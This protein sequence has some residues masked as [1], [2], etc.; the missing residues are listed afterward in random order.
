MATPVKSG[1]EFKANTNTTGA[2]QNPSIAGLSG[3]GF[4][5]TWTSDQDS[6]DSYGIYAQR[7]QADGTAVGSEF[8][9]NTFTTGFQYAPAVSGLNDGGFIV[10]W[11][12][13]GQAGSGSGSG[14]GYYDVFGQRYDANGD[15]VGSEFQINS[16]TPFNQYYSSVAALSDGG[17]VVTWTDTAQ[18]QAGFGGY[19]VYGQRYTSAGIATGGEFHI[20]THT[21]D[22]Q[23]FSDV[24]AFSGGG[25]VVV[26]ESQD[27]DTS[28]F[29]WGIYGQR[30][31]SNG[32]A[33]GTEFRIN[34]HVAGD[35][36]FPTVTSLASGFVVT[37][38]SD[39]QDGS[40]MGIY[41]QRFAAN[42][43]ASGSEFQIN[44]YT[45]SL[46]DRPDVT[47]LSDGGFVVTWQSYGQDG[48]GEGV[49]GQRFDADGSTNGSEFLV[50]T[51][52]GSD[53]EDPTI[54]ALSNGDFAVAWVATVNNGGTWSRDIFGQVFSTTGPRFT[55]GDDTVVLNDSGETV[56]ALGGN[57][58]VG[59]G[60]G[61]DNI[62]GGSGSDILA[63]AGGN[64]TLDGGS[65]DVNE[66]D[67]L[68]G[69]AGNDTYIVNSTTSA[70]DIVDEGTAAPT[71]G[72]VDTIISKGDFFWDYY[73][74]GEILTIDPSAP[75]GATVVASKWDCTLNGNDKDNILLPY[76]NDNTINP[77]AGVDVIGL[78]L[79]GLD[80]TFNG[81]N[82][83]NFT[84]GDDTNYIYD[85]ESGTD[86]ID[87]SAYGR[88]ADG[89]QMLANVADTDWGSFV[90]MG[91]HEGADEY[92]G[93]VGL[94]QADLD[95]GDFMV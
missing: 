52:T 36:R 92:I 7:Y 21:D 11:Q 70:I 47:A 68:Y 37:W 8:Q 87:V 39:G 5:V 88:F 9:V 51:N 73:N 14:T 53:E 94:H 28:G 40:S 32:A 83:M 85:F 6:D 44:T 4:V 89:A 23:D 43:T 95:A 72:E 54:T 29:G 66:I 25:F 2:Q 77:G 17:Y 41:G 56:D 22:H 30:Y 67:Y 45:D 3:G 81:T 71:P 26:W 20:N 84:P 79:Y 24:A 27:Q 90:W 76:G 13:E 93:I 35:Q 57:D 74:V 50:P 58:I 12:S 42:G 48:A 86:K 80:S 33:A 49:Y 63:G 91:V 75:S 64:D 55:E 31:D 59:G 18:D 38:E 19:G 65:T 82:T 1:S 60:A 62:F 34:T 61:D 16:T 10:T 15:L 46:Q 78:G 69:G